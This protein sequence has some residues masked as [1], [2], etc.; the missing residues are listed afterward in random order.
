MERIT[1]ILGEKVVLDELAKHPGG[2]WPVTELDC[3]SVVSPNDMDLA[4][5]DL[6]L[7]KLEHQRPGHL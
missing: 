3:C 4:D 1:E 7:I 2:Y 5:R 6:V